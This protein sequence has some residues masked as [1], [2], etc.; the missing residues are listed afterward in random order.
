MCGFSLK[1][2]K[3]N[4]KLREL[5]G[6]ESVSLAITNGKSRWSGLMKYKDKADWVYDRCGC[7]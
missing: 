2:R 5:L 6:L 4:K 7:N 3:R 1:E